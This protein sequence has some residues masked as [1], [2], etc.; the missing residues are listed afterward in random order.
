MFEKDYIINSEY[1]ASHPNMT[2]KEY[3][4]ERKILN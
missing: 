1:I 4:D 3:L 2:L